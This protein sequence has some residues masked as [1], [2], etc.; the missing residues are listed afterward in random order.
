MGAS[1]TTLVPPI[2]VIMPGETLLFFLVCPLTHKLCWD[3]T[4]IAG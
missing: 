2:G 3:G 4:A 1:G